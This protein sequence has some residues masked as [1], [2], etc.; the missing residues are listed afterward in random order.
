[1][2]EQ[3]KN[4]KDALLERKQKEAEEQNAKREGKGTRIRV[5]QTRGKNPQVVSWEAFDESK[6]ETLPTS[7]DEFMKLSGTK[8]EATYLGYLIEGFNSAQ[9]TAASDP[10]AE[11][12][13]A[14]WSDEVQKQFRTAVR[15]YANAVGAPIDE[16]VAL[17]KP[18]LDKKYPKPTA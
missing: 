14:H 6:P 17:I 4:E 2:S 1:M 7:V 9:Y 10:L 15:Q 13:E 16:A 5:G 12:V 18:G 8:D 3:E 11:Y